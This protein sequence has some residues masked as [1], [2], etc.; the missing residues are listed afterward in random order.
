MGVLDDIFS[1][2][3]AVPGDIGGALESDTAK[4]IYAS[5]PAAL[6]AAAGARGNPGGRGVQAL[7]QGISNAF[8]NSLAEERKMRPQ[9][10]AAEDVWKMWNKGGNFIGPLD[11]M[12]TM[13]RGF[14]Q[15]LIH[16]DPG[17]AVSMMGAD[18][19]RDEKE[20]LKQLGSEPKNPFQQF[21]ASEHTK[22]ITN[23]DQIWQDWLDAQA[24]QKKKEQ[25]AKNGYPI[26]WGT[27]MNG[28]V[29]GMGYP[30]EVYSKI[31]D[32]NPA[33][34]AQIARQARAT[35]NGDRIKRG[36]ATAS[37]VDMAKY[38]NN[39][40]QKAAM[41]VPGMRDVVWVNP[42]TK[43]VDARSRYL[44]AEQLNLAGD[45]PLDKQSG[46]SYIQ[47]R[48]ALDEM[49]RMKSDLKTA[50]GT[51]PPGV[52]LS[53]VLG[54]P[55]R[56]FINRID[57]QRFAKFEAH[58]LDLADQ[59]GRLRTGGSMRSKTLFDAHK[60]QLEGYHDTLNSYIQKLNTFGQQISDNMDD[61]SG[62]QLGDQ[63]DL[64]G[65]SQSPPPVIVAPSA[66]DEGVDLGG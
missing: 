29:A 15:D 32:T 28:I 22:G 1:K 21:R 5:L 31:L 42:K 39:Y 48:A 19:A 17:L 2:L 43:R 63:P 4:E 11:P 20:K 6:G 44:P 34:A 14:M 36:I 8:L 45:V 49:N 65:L 40:T 37:G 50:I 60:D 61:I 13:N 51:L 24:E 30:P 7:G 3:S 25:R 18:Q 56:N 16:Q 64:S 46:Q 52:T 9:R 53:S 33:L 47:G 54:Q 58:V 38:N 62:Y 10:A 27:E 12:A 59:L 23:D 66:N 55:A 57:P 26:Q 41:Q 35:L